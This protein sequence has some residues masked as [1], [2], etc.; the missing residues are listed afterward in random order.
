M[1]GLVVQKHGCA[2]VRACSAPGP[3]AGRNFPRRRIYASEVVNRI[4]RCAATPEAAS[5]ADIEVEKEIRPGVTEGVWKWREYNIRYQKSG[6]SGP[7]IV[8]VHGFGGNC[9][10]WRRNIDELGKRHRVFTLDLLGYGFS[11]KPD[12]RD[13]QV[14]SIY[15]FDVWSDQVID[16]VDQVIGGQ[17]KVFITSNSV[18][19]IVALETAIKSPEKVASVQVI[20]VSLRMLHLEKQA[21]LAR[22]FIE[23]LQRTLRTSM[24]GPLFFKQIATEQGVRNVLQQCYRNKLSVTDELVNFILKPGLED[25]AV[26]VFL[27]FISY[28][29][30][31]LP[32]KQLQHCPVPVSIL[33]GESDP[34]EKIEWGKSFETYECVEEFVALPGVGHCPQDES[35]ELVNPLIEKWVSRH[36]E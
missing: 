9:D 34:W 29:S 19:G 6:T 17:E 18:G 21:V 13:S 31:P 14:N 24:L 33:W 26:H 20:N 4:V 16:F 1:F 36:S 30:G 2:S 35:P 27:D 15:N 23:L 10:H 7:V 32:E 3:T 5:K 22:P 25:G 8:A 28:S 11:S 12:P